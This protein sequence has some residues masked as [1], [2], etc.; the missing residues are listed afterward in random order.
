MFKFFGVVMIVSGGVGLIVDDV[1]KCCV[2]E[3][4]LVG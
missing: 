4:L 1:T 3:K 2:V